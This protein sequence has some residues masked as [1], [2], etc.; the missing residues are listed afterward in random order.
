[1]KSL[2]PARPYGSDGV[3]GDEYWDWIHQPKFNGWRFLADL[4]TGE[5]FNR[6]G[7]KAKNESLVLKRLKGF[8]FKSRFVD[9]EICGMRT[10]TG[11]GTIIVIDSFD[12]ENP[13][14]IQGRLK[15]FEE[16][17]PASFNVRSNALL[18]MPSLNHKNLRHCWQEMDYQN[19]KA[20]ETI[21]EGFVSKKDSK[22]PWLKNPDWVSM[23]WHK[24]RITP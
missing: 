15:E 6:K 1:M 23:E 14:P 16:I 7:G 19:K 20:G 3:F 12:P 22:Y 4:A 5:V 13:K 11:A 17:E 2:H 24:M 9:G 10:K 8:G 21:W 18:R